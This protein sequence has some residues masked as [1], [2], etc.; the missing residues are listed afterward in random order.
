MSELWYVYSPVERPGKKTWW[1]KLGIAT[2]NKDG[3]INATLT[4]L[5]VNGV[6]QLRKKVTFVAVGESQTGPWTEDDEPPPFG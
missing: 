5:P 2:T 3:S 6:I 4:A 1:Q